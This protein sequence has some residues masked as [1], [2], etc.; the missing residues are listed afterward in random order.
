MRRRVP[1]IAFKDNFVALM[2][3]TKMTKNLPAATKFDGSIRKPSFSN[4]AFN[5]LQ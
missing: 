2:E 4:L 1:T 3:R 5:L